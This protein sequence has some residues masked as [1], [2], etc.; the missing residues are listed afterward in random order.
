M[1]RIKEYFKEDRQWRREHRIAHAKLQLLNSD[2]Q[3]IPFWKE[4]LNKLEGD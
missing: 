4:V 2:P 1:T 3:D